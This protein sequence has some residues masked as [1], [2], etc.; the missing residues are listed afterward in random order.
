[1]ETP[2]SVGERMSL[3]FIDWLLIEASHQRAEGFG[4]G[5]P[6]VLGQLRQTLKIVF[7]R[8]RGTEHDEKNR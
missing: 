4:V 7:T 3:W 6:P 8:I 2:R 1:M 5:S